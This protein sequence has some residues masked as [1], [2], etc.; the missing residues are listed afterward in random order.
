VAEILSCAGILMFS[1]DDAHHKTTFLLS[2][3]PQLCCGA[4]RCNLTQ[5]QKQ[6][7]SSM[8]MV[9]SFLQRK[10]EKCRKKKTGFAEWLMSMMLNSGRTIGLQ[11]A[12]YD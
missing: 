7:Q 5:V 10:C 11:E 8:P 4:R 6:V 2:N 3:T 12:R 9:G 1:A